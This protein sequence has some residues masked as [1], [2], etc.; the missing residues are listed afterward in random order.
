MNHDDTSTSS[1][2]DSSSQMTPSQVTPNQRN[3]STAIESSADI[4]FAIEPSKKSPITLAAT[5]EFASRQSAFE[6]TQLSSA[7]AVDNFL[8][9]PNRLLIFGSLG[10][11]GALGLGALAST[12]ITYRTTIKAKAVVYPSDEFQVIQSSGEGT[13]RSI[14]AQNYDSLKLDQVIATLDNP[15]L[16]TEVIN[17]EAQIAQLEEQVTRI[18]RKITELEYR[19][20]TQ[21]S[22]RNTQ[23]SIDQSRAFEYSRNLLLG[24]RRD[25]DAQLEYQHNRLSQAEQKIDNMI[26]RSPTAGILYDLELKNLGQNVSLDVPVAKIVPE[27]TTLEIKALIPDANI[28]NITVGQQAHI[29]LSNCKPFSFGSMQGQVSSIEPTTISQS[30]EFTQT[31]ESKYNVTVKAESQEVKSGLRTCK[32]LP[33]IKGEITIISK[34]EKLWDFFLRKLRFKANV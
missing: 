30:S 32:L 33:G 18:N 9:S 22:S 21:A 5:Q 19:Q 26:V 25:L 24:H 8:P 10:L 15:R 14:L 4:D 23:F 13:V 28:K 3:K 7:S 27:G 1:M 12:L 2:F 6:E 29:N 31:A 20:A 11:A 17:T 16:R 34:Q